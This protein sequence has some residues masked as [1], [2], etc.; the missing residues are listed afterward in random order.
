MGMLRE[1]VYRGRRAR[2][3]NRYQA[4]LAS[5]PPP[6]NVMDVIGFGDTG[7]VEWAFDG[8]AEVVDSDQCSELQIQEDGEAWFSPASTYSP[9]SEPSMCVQ[10]DYTFMFDPGLNYFWQVPSSPAGIVP[11]ITPDVGVVQIYF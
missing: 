11:D 5:A 8:V 10:A 2:R 6:I 1:R 4:P 3:T 7:T 9:G